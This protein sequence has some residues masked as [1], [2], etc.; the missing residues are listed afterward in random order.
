MA[1]NTF[2]VEVTFKECFNFPGLLEEEN[3]A[4]YITMSQIYR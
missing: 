4:S 3:L 2:V 1:N